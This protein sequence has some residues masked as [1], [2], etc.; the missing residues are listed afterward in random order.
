MDV[1]TE[2]YYRRDLALV[3]DRGFGFHA[4]GCAAGVIE[5]LQ[6]IRE[7]D[8]VVLELGCGS[9]RLTRH[10]LDA[11]HRVIATDASPAMLALARDA[12]PDVEE[13]RQLALPDGPLPTADAVVSVGHSL[14]YLPTAEDIDTA[15]TSIAAALRPGGI[16]AIDLCDL[17]WGEV[18]RDQRNLGMAGEDWALITEFSMPTPDRYVRDMTTFVKAE[19]GTWR[20]GHERHDNVLID[21]AQ[22]LPLLSRHGVES[23]IESAFG[24]YAL[25]E[26]LFAIVGRRR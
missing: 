23:R 19:D 15:L 17:R 7:R 11:G 1:N 6:P 10:L 26:G 25:P 24:Q 22:V 14:N 3:H 18:R 12:V 5:L 2:P 21:T 13:L 20:R 4:D 16:L 9:G 8:G